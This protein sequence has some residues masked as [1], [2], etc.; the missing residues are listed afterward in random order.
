VNEVNE[1][2]VLIVGAGIGGVALVRALA[3]VGIP[4]RVY[5]RAPALREVGSGLG[6]TPNAVRALE[7]LGLGEQVREIGAPF[8]A[9]EFSND[10][11]R[12]L[13]R[14]RIRDIDPEAAGR[15]FV[16]HRAELHRALLD[17][18]PDGIVHPDAECVGF[19]DD[20]AGV[21][22]RQ[23]DGAEVRGRALVGAD[24]LHSVVRRQLHGQ[25]PTRYSGQTC[26]RGIAAMPPPH[27]GVLREVQGRGLRC[28][29]CPLD[30]ARV[31]WWAAVNAPEGESDDPAGRRE[32]VLE[33]FAGW[34]FGF[35]EMVRRTP[36]DAILR[37][38]LVDRGPNA[39][40]GR[41]R[42]TLL[43]DAAH[44]MLPNLGQGACTA[45]EDAVVLA[46]HLATEP[47]VRAAL[48]GYERER[49]RRTTRV[50]RDSWIFGVLAKWES[51][52]AVRLRELTL[53]LTPDPVLWR[54][55]RFYMGY[56]TGPLP[57]AAAP[58]DGGGDAPAGEARAASGIP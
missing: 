53:R 50:V 25:R 34:P 15:T 4:C 29:I 48:R 44:P 56:D 6:V 58:P 19:A 21:T 30:D 42:V 20:G 35:P 17:G 38:D 31:Y 26:Y 18:V 40:W 55:A 3:R 14:T 10:A 23:R 27:P 46:R 37:N 41:G 1:S 2:P 32:R 22:L 47:D 7:H 52:L 24:G 16:M 28:G 8:E 11:G 36:A 45:I 51:P 5:E 39:R 57:A 54:R 13:G 12:T 33:T 9:A 43:G 49:H